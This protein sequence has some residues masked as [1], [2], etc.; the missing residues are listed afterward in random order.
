[1]P[2]IK[3]DFPALPSGIESER[4]NCVIMI[5]VGQ[6]YH[7]PE[8]FEESLKL[9][10]KK[11][12]YHRITLLSHETAEPFEVPTQEIY[13]Q[14][15]ADSTYLTA[16]WQTA[17]TVEK[18]QIAAQSLVKHL[19]SLASSHSHSSGDQKLINKFTSQFNCEQNRYGK[20]TIIVAG[21]LQLFTKM[22][23]NSLLTEDEA[24]SLALQDEEAWIASSTPI[25]DRVLVGQPYQIVRWGECLQ[26]PLY[27]EAMQLTAARYENDHDF[28]TS[29]DN[30]VEKFMHGFDSKKKTASSDISEQNRKINLCKAYVL[31]ETALVMVWQKKECN[32][33]WIPGASCFFLA[34]PFGG[35]SSNK[36]I[37]DH[38]TRLCAENAYR[39]INIC[40]PSTA[41]KEKKAAVSEEEKQLEVMAGAFITMANAAKLAP[42]AQI[43]L[44][45]LA[46][47]KVQSRIIIQHS[48]ASGSQAS[49]PS[50]GQKAAASGA[51]LNNKTS[52]PTIETQEHTNLQNTSASFF[53]NE[54]NPGSKAETR[55]S[56]IL[57]NGSLG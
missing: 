51:P 25:I 44:F 42:E 31:Q 29:I 48:Q 46:A 36:V 20:Y 34:Y 9:L 37:Y 33:T 1:M 24:R 35:H 53:S 3:I 45:A 26:N 14:L 22:M 11:K 12:D 16:Y 32:T 50:I 57:A 21:E 28:H 2:N 40:V 54:I 43:A 17:E 49:M 38:L 23:T 41:K 6:S 19:N 4:Q 7:A 55:T 8:P 47:Q 18:E 15:S 13:V 30:I 39:L 56:Q 52:K 5:S 27:P 10:A